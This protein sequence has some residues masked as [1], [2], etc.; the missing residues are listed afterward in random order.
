MFKHK[1]Q[2]AIV[3]QK[4]CMVNQLI[5]E[6]D[7]HYPDE[8]SKEKCTIYQARIAQKVILQDVLKT[9]DRIGS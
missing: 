7:K 1:K 8:E 4:L 6:L 9:F 3:E 5:S 2:R